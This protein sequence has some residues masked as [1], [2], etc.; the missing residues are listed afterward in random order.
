MRVMAQYTVDKHMLRAF[1]CTLKVCDSVVE[2]GLI[3]SMI[4][5][6]GES[7]DGGRSWIVYVTPG[8]GATTAAHFIMHGKH[9]YCP[10]RALF[11]EGC[12]TYDL[13]KNLRMYVK[14]AVR[15]STSLPRSLCKS[16]VTAAPVS[17][18][19]QKL[20]AHA[21]GCASTKDVDDGDDD[22]NEYVVQKGTQEDKL[23]MAS[24]SRIKLLN[25][26]RIEKRPQAMAHEPTPVLIIDDFDYDSPQNRGLA[27]EL[28]G[29]ASAFNVAVFFLVGDMDF[30][31]E[32]TKLDGDILEPVN[33]V[34]ATED[35][36]EVWTEIGCTDEEL[37][38]IIRPECNENRINPADVIPDRAVPGNEGK[39]LKPHDL[40]RKIN[41]LV[42]ERRTRNGTEES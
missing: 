7:Q 25:S 11:I 12:G 18:S 5:C 16:L 4:A 42:R 33:E 39:I 41:R 17:F 19:F 22:D 37:M 3:R 21:L 15:K 31:N 10:R 29:A 26:H 36:G 20:V 8:Q 34:V 1:A 24:R 2:T 30:A 23:N 27:Y 40:F 32:L 38:A 28:A 13:A 14:C 35:Q 6:L 9:S